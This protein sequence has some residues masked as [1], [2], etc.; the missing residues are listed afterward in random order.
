MRRNVLPKF[1]EICIK[2][3]VG[4]QHGGQK[5]AE[6][7][8]T[9]WVLLQERKLISRGTL[10]VTTSNNRRNNY[11]PWSR[12]PWWLNFQLLRAKASAAPHLWVWC[13]PLGPLTIE[14]FLFHPLRLRGILG[15]VLEC[16]GGL[17]LRPKKNPTQVSKEI[18]WQ[19]QFFGRS[20]LLSGGILRYKLFACFS[21]LNDI[22]IAITFQ[23]SVQILQFSWSAINRAVTIFLGCTVSQLKKNDLKTTQCIKSRNYD[24]K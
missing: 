8:V 22:Y 19:R 11:V 20:S 7:S 15:F 16:R 10:S 17:V 9:A 3:P 5:P 6:T 24:V 2:T 18:S 12:P 13:R 14:Q 23:E 21:L 4:L 1:I